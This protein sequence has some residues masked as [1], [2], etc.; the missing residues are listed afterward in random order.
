MLHFIGKC[1]LS[2]LCSKCSLITA[3][4]CKTRHDKQKV[5]WPRK[6]GLKGLP[7]SGKPFIPFWLLQSLAKFQR[8]RDMHFKTHKEDLS[9][10][11]NISINAPWI[12]PKPFWDCQKNFQIKQ[13]QLRET[14]GHW[15]VKDFKL[16]RNFYIVLQLRIEDRQFY[17]FHRLEFALL[18][19]RKPYFYLLLHRN[20]SKTHLLK[21]L[22]MKLCFWKHY[23]A[24]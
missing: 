17:Y 24:C 9:S 1:T 4:R 23:N 7:S 2:S 8:N 18:M 10:S 19:S 14:K 21:K 20:N 22:W 13:T 11:R 15:R 12:A 5:S 6:K 16:E 3:S